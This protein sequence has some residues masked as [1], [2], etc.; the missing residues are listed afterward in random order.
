MVERTFTFSYKGTWVTYAKKVETARVGTAT[1]FNKSRMGQHGLTDLRDNDL[2]TMEFLCRSSRARKLRHSRT[3]ISRD[4]YSEIG[5]G[6]NPA[7]SF[8]FI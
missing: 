8:F 5:N 7:L 6:N 1:I 4:K 3:A 2:C